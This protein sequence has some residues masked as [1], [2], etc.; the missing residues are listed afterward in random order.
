M[1]SV[2]AFFIGTLGNALRDTARGYYY[3]QF[4]SVCDEVIKETEKSSQ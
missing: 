1:N 2:P 4:H 3:A